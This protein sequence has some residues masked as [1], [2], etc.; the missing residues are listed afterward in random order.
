[1]CRLLLLLAHKPLGV[2]GGV[3]YKYFVCVVLLD[4]MPNK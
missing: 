1:M 2:L 3:F 4:D